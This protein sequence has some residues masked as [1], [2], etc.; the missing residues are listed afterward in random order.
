MRYLNKIRPF[1]FFLAFGLG[2][3]YIY[4]VNPGPKI[5]V[6]HPTPDNAGVLVYR[7][8]AGNCYKYDKELVTCPADGGINHPIV[9]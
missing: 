1:Y 8:K 7:D 3:L 9:A 2:I 5:V 4:M 6:K